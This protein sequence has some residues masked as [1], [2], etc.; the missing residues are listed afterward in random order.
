MEFSNAM[1]DAMI[2]HY[3]QKMKD[4]AL[5]KTKSDNLSGDSQQ[6]MDHLEVIE[7]AIQ[8]AKAEYYPIKK[9]A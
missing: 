6:W 8:N 3:L 2:L 4:N 7:R 9:T 5:E 1:E